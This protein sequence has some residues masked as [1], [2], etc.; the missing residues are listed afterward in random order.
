MF[1]NGRVWLGALIYFCFVMGL[2]GVSFWLPTI[3]KATGVSDPLNVGLLTA[4]PYAFAAAAMVL[5]GRSAD[6]RC[7]GLHRWHRCAQ[8]VILGLSAQRCRLV[9]LALERFLAIG[10][11]GVHR[12]QPARLFLHA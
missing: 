10:G 5:I 11:S 12:R 3:I 8:C 9:D 2:Y 6:A 7:A 1:A 4:I